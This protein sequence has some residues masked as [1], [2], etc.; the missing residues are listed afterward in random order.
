MSL[1]QEALKRQQQETEGIL[2]AEPTTEAPAVAPPPPTPPTEETP[3]PPPPPPPPEPPVS[4]V[5]PVDLP[6]KTPEPIPETVTVESESKPT[7][8]L[9]ALLGV[10]LLLALLLFVV[11]WAIYYGLQ[12][13]GEPVEETPETGLIAPTVSTPVTEPQ[14]APPT[15]PPA[16]EP[17]PLG[18]AVVVETSPVEST[19]KD[20]DTDLAAEAANSQGSPETEIPEEAPA[21]TSPAKTQPPITQPLPNIQW[22]P[23][24]L[25]GIVGSG[26]S[27]AVMINGKVIGINESVDGIEIV[28]IDA[29]G[30]LLEYKGDRRFLKEGKSLQ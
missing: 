23:V 3:P 4:P 6:E 8:V 14:P 19:A 15:P 9:P 24:K 13:I 20:A 25:S 17:A 27:G 18:E 1:I 10:I 16:A 30:A 11:G 28:S 26:R 5:D 29:K 2:P 7:R 12:Y 22:P 21:A